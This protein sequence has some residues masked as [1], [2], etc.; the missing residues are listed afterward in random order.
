MARSI[1]VNLPPAEYRR[2]ERRALDH[3]RDP[4]QEARAI[5]RAAIAPP[6]DAEHG[7]TPPAE[8]ERR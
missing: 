7:L 5:V 3:D 8:G 4:W 1:V 6:P 2:L